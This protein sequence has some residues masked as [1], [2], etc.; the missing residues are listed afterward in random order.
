MHVV[1]S[2]DGTE[3][4]YETRGDGQPLVLVH[5][6]SARKESFRD[7]VPHL[8]DDFAVVT[9]DRRG[10]GA[11]GDGDDYRFEREVEDLRAIVE[12]VGGDPIVLGHSFGGLVALEAADGLDIDRLVLY[13]PSILVGEPHG[14]DLAERIRARLAAGDRVGA[15]EVFLDAVG[16]ADLLPQQAVEQAAGIVETVAREIEVVEDYDLEDPETGVP[17]LLV[18]GEHGPDHL[19]EAVEA[20]D[21]ALA[22]TERTELAGVGHLGINTAPEQ[23]ADAVRE[24][25][26]N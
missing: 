13:E 14:G 12:A 1:T 9:Y 6:T 19:R 24:F 4:G 15:V 16:A 26:Q 8:A 2:A 20:L 23:L 5:G 22:E 11:S 21:G 25:A 17:T 3:L 10:R 7:L 18:L